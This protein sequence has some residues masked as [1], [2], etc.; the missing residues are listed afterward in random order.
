MMLPNNKIV[1]D[2]HD[3]SG[4][5]ERE[6]AANERLSATTSS[7]NNSVTIND[8]SGTV[9]VD[10]SAAANNTRKTELSFPFRCVYCTVLYCMCVLSRSIGRSSSRC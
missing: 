1:H 2:W 10:S 9:G 4:I 8:G 5:S 3:Y 6:A 7:S